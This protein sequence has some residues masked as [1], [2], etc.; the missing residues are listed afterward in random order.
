MHVFWVKSLPMSVWQIKWKEQYLVARLLCWIHVRVSQCN[1]DLCYFQPSMGDTFVCFT[2]SFIHSILH[3]YS[4]NFCNGEPK[5][6]QMLQHLTNYFF[7]SYADS[8]HCA[9]W[10]SWIRDINSGG[11]YS[12]IWGLGTNWSRDKF[13]AYPPFWQASVSRWISAFLALPIDTLP[14]STCSKSHRW[15]WRRH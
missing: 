3:R 10:I 14:C 5:N 6:Y 8:A 1:V 13:L 9:L 12:G 11:D 15:Q 2:H 4:G 7:C